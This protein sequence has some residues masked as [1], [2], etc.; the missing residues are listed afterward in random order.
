MVTATCFSCHL[1]GLRGNCDCPCC[2]LTV[3]R[4]GRSCLPCVNVTLVSSHRLG[5]EKASRELCG[6]CKPSS[7]ATSLSARGLKSTVGA[8]RHFLE[9][10]QCG[11]SG[12]GASSWPYCAPDINHLSII[13]LGF[14]ACTHLEQPLGANH[15]AFT[16]QCL[17]FLV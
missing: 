15:R 10:L 4:N 17:S 11:Q 5:L 1:W 14:T 2:F 12:C 6:T 8:G 16:G 7:G 3:P 9:I 13:Q